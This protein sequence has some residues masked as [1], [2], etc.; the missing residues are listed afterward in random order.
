M[1]YWDTYSITT[2]TGPATEPVTLDDAKAFLYVRNVANDITIRN[3]ISAARQ[4]TE[5]YCRQRWI[6]QTLRIDL[7]RFPYGCSP[8]DLLML[9]VQPI[10]SV[11]SVYYTNTEGVNT[12]LDS[13]DYQTW[14]THSPPIIAPARNK[15]WPT[16]DYDTLATVR[17]TVVAGYGASHVNVPPVVKQAILTTIGYWFQHRGDSD[18]PTTR[19]LP[20]GARHS[21]DLAFSGSYR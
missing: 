20:N 13:A 7:P 8:H 2:V 11:T 10:S 18:D 6:N 12:L 9:P 21:L 1:N 14:L 16:V 19:G 17:I 4:M 3:M 15:V 5:E